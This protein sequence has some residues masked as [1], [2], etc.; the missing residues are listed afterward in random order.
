MESFLP[1]AFHH[2]LSNTVDIRCTVRKAKPMVPWRLENYLHDGDLQFQWTVTIVM[3]T[4]WNMA[5][6]HLFFLS[7]SVFFFLA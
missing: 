3:V 4:L 7:S 1:D 5:S 2:L 6:C